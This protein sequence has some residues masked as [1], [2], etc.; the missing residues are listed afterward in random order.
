MNSIIDDYPTGFPTA[1]GPPCLSLYQPTHRSH[2]DRQQDPIRF[3][4]FVKA[5][6]ES[7]RETYPTREIERLLEPF[8]ALAADVSFW[9]HTRAGLAVLGA[10]GVFRVHRL[11]RSVPELAVVAD[12]FHTKPLLRIL[13]S[14]DRYQ[15]LGVSR[16]MIRLFE[17]NRDALDE[18]ELATEVPK[19]ITDALGEDI[20]EPDVTVF[21]FGKAGGR[22]LYSGHGSKNDEKQADAERFFRVVDRAI[23]E[24]HSRP[25][26]LPLIL[27]ALPEHHALFRRVSHN[28]YL[29]DEGIGV[30][31]D[32]VTIDGLR[33][34]A[35]RVVEPYYLGRLASLIEEFTAA[36]SRELG[37]ADLAQVAEA[38]VAGRVGTLLIDADR[39]VAGRI[40]RATGH[41]DLS[42]LTRPDADDILDDLAEIV[43]AMKGR[44]VV[45]PTARMPTKTGVAAIYRY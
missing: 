33:E 42:D 19:T 20:T 43:V 8:H 28:A 7:L 1:Q 40:D 23:L 14:A 39:E 41:L 5:L 12:S 21:S 24:H 44:V 45:V 36:T 18:V 31:P 16:Q 9:N 2:P 37:S 26:G 15:I 27:A 17:G 22:A 35:W 38:A 11:Q 25:S 13:Q 29:V 3:R 34:R 32:A 10:T 4:N 30:N 6:E